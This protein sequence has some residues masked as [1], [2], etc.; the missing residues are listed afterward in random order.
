FTSK[1]V[2]SDSSDSDAGADGKTGYY[3]L[4]SGSNVT[5]VDAG[6]KQAVVNT[7]KVGDRVWE[8]KNFNGV[9][10]AGESGISGVTVKLLNS[11]GGVVATTTTN[12][13]GNYQFSNLAAGNYKVQVVAPSGYYVTKLDQGSDGALDSDVGSNGTTASFSL[14]SGQNLTSIDAGLYRKASIG[15]KVWSD[16]D[17]DYVQDVGECGIRNV[18][19][20]LQDSCGNTIAVTY[21]NNNGNYCFSNLDPGTYRVVF[22]KTSGYDA[23]GNSVYNWGWAPKDVGGNDQ[24]DADA[25]SAWGNQTATTAYTFLESGEN[26]MSWDAACTPIVIDLGGDGIQTVSRENSLGAFDLFG[27]GTAISSG[28]ISGHDGFL[29]IDSNGNGSIDDISELFGGTDKGQGFAKL[30]S[31]DSNGDGLV[32]ASD[33]RFAELKIWQDV[34]GDHQT[35]A[36]ELMSLAQAGV[37]ALTVSYTE[38][39]FLDANHN[40]HLE[41]ST[42]T[43]ADGSS[44][45]MTDVYFNVAKEDAAAAGV[46]LPSMADLLGDDRSVDGLLGTEFTVAADGSVSSQPCGT[47]AGASACLEATVDAEALRRLAQLVSASEVALG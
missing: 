7:A 31:F 47:T 35:D 24:L 41:R 42:A 22:D 29:A 6:L 13:S 30:A 25:Y 28:W 8:D 16:Y 46:T 23:W 17:H 2:G 26:D 18:K 38:L 4:T 27:T 3:T 11:A 44:V 9:Q 10:D 32:N 33:E 12:S 36:G 37:A 19:V 39:P 15:D 40:L 43:M 1:D 45:D 20:M 21:T 14:A 34:D 5:T